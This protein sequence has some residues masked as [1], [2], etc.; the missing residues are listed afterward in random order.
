MKIEIE[1]DDQLIR[2]TLTSAFEGGSNYWYYIQRR[3]GRATGTEFPTHPA[4]VAM[5]AT[6]KVWVE[7]SDGSY[8][9]SNPGRRTVVHLR[10][11]RAS[12]GRTT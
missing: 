2:D 11:L 12:R 7:H 6:G 4:Y 8:G 10:A 5:S 9:S 3:E 1:I